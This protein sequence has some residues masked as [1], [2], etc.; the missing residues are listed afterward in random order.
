MH[1]QRKKEDK[2]GE[3]TQHNIKKHAHVSFSFY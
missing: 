3:K 2:R 1:R